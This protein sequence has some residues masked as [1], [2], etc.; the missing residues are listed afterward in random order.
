M[1]RQVVVDQR[2]YNLRFRVAEANVEF[3]DFWSLTRQHEAGIQEAAVLVAVGAH[4]RD[5]RT[6]D[7]LHDPLAHRAVNERARG[8][9]PHATGVRA[10]VAVERTLVV[11]GGS[12]RHRARA[13][14]ER[15]KRDFWPGETLLEYDAR[16]SIAE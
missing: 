3:D 11:L 7:L 12:Q 10:A 6:H 15:E 1:R 9:R 16:T 14:A 8:K 5:N 2:Q 4:P 13:I